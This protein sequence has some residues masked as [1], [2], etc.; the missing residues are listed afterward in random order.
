MTTNISLSAT[1]RSHRNTN[2]TRQDY[3]FDPIDLVANTR[4]IRTISEMYSGLMEETISPRLTLHLIGVQVA[5]FFTI[6]PA[7]MPVFTR[8]ACLAWLATSVGL[9]KHE[10]CKADE[11]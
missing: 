3:T 6:M 7:E 9:A 8:I 11:R 10:Y 5:A 1:N 2:N 4:V